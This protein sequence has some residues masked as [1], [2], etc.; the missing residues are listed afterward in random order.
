MEGK[1]CIVYL[2]LSV[3]GTGK[4]TSVDP[5]NVPHPANSK[6]HVKNNKD[7]NHPRD[8]QT[9]GMPDEKAGKL[10]QALIFVVHPTASGHLKS[11][12]E[13]F[14]TSLGTRG[15]QRFKSCQREPLPAPCSGLEGINLDEMKVLA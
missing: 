6:Q 4:Q 3:D 9:P 10:G 11:D 13:S 5:L 15:D 12:L 7:D 1:P 14:S 8:A 2:T